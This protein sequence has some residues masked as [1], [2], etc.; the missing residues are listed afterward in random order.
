MKSE[1]KI[2]RRQLLKSSTIAVGFAA[3]GPLVWTSGS[4]AGTR[5]SDFDR[6]YFDERVGSWFHVDAG[7]YEHLE[8][9]EVTGIDASP[10]LDQ[11]IVRLR[12]SP[13]V[14]IAE[15][16][17]EVWPPAGEAFALHIQPAGHDDGGSYYEAAFSIIKPVSPSCAGPA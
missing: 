5:A 6:A 11:F 15:G 12:G 3:F 10:R 1:L 9:V 2:G 14:E 13:H 8:L 4:R 17:Y 16:L 7:S